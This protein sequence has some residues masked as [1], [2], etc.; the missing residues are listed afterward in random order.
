MLNQL[1]IE[2]NTY[3]CI[4][5]LWWA[6][7]LWWDWVWCG[8]IAGRRCGQNMLWRCMHI[9]HIMA[10]WH[11]LI[12]GWFMLNSRKGSSASI[13]TSLFCT[14]EIPRMRTQ[15]IGANAG[16]NSNDNWW[17]VFRLSFN[18]DS[19]WFGMIFVFRFSKKLQTIQ[20]VLFVLTA[21]N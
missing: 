11:H 14:S 9:M 2:R 16:R 21:H 18:E 4:R 12:C 8:R 7:L 20:A 10:H 1:T 19:Y 13:L 6:R 3:H 15:R 5:S 17:K